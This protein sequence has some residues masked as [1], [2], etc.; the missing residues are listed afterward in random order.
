M[1]VE[2][3]LDLGA[4]YVRAAGDDHVLGEIDEKR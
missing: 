1:L 2:G 3:V 4:V